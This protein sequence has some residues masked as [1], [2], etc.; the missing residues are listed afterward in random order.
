MEYMLIWLWVFLFVQ[1][2]KRKY[3]PP[4][5]MRVGKKKRSRGPETANKLPQGK[6][7]KIHEHVHAAEAESVYIVYIYFST[8]RV[9][10][11]C[12]FISFLFFCSFL[13]FSYVEY[14]CSFV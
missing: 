6:C 11:Q 1:E 7:I 12:L 3:E 13:L 2:K 10:C 5:P 4:I 14:D 8:L 9:D